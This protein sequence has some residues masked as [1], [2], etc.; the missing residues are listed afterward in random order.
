M[1]VSL[2]TRA[3]AVQNRERRDC[4]KCFMISTTPEVT[5]Y[6]MFLLEKYRSNHPLLNEALVSPKNTI[7]ATKWDWRIVA[8]A[9]DVRKD[10]Q[11]YSMSLTVQISSGVVNE[12]YG[13]IGVIVS[14]QRLWLGFY[15]V[16]ARNGPGMWC[17]TGTKALGY[18]LLHG[19]PGKACFLNMCMVLV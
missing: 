7:L 9:N 6:Y 12:R 18:M 8:L 10:Q 1:L 5:L 16:A 17:R 14:N 2:T 19:A 15:Q 13:W 11:C 3:G 4:N